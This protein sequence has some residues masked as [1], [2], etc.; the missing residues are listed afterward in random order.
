MDEYY[1]NKLEESN[2]FQDH[3]AKQFLLQRGIPLQFFCSKKNQIHGECIQGYELKYDSLFR[4]TKRLYIE[5]HEKQNMA[6][7]WVESGILKVDN[8]IYLVIGDYELVFIFSK[9]QLIEEYKKVYWNSI[10]KNTSK[11]FV[12]DMYENGTINE[13]F[14]HLVLDKIKSI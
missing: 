5:T 6:T 10:E 3:W 14:K 13:R 9:Q 8:S 4:K 12:I 1:K 7:Q 11:G 2:L